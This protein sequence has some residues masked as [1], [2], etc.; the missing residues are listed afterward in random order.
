M[1]I[2][3][4]GADMDDATR[5]A[6]LA[7]FTALYE[8]MGRLGLSTPLVADGAS[9][10]LGSVAPMLGRLTFVLVAEE[11][12][13]Q[14]GF[15][16]GTIRSTPP[17]LGSERVGMLTHIH[18]AGEARGRGLGERLVRSLRAAFADRGVLRME[19]DALSGNTQAQRFFEK[20]GFVADH[21]V[22]RLD[23]ERS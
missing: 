17:H 10:W 7:Q 19:T 8:H 9:L 13:E 6:V 21:V 2:R 16:A 5:T 18:V 23:A 11:G 22:Y 15:V 1:E 14:R 4:L 12:G 20:Q 3:S